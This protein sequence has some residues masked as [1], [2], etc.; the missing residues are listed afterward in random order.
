MFIDGDT[1][2]PT[3]SG[4]GAEDYIGSAWELGEFINRYQGCVMRDGNA[5]SMYRFHVD[6]PICFEKDICVTIQAM[7]GGMAEKVKNVLENGCPCIPVTYDNGELHHIYKVDSDLELSGYVNFYRI[8]H[9]RIVAYY[10]KK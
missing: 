4:T 3:L 5:V 7:G 2:Y 10:Y 8:D 1:Q 9:Y 6:D